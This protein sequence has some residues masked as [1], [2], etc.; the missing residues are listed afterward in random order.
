MISITAADL[1]FWIA[2]FIY[3]LTRILAFAA[4]APLWS[5]ASMP[6][7][8]RLLLGLALTLGLAPALPPMPATTPGTWS[9]LWLLSQQ[10]LI[11]I[12]MGLSMRIVYTA[13]NMA[14]ELIGLQMGLGFA[15][16]YDPQTAG[17]TPVIAEFLGIL[18]MLVF[19]SLNGHLLFAATLAQSFT[20]IPVS[21][22]PLAH[23]SWLNIAELGG[24]IFASGLLLSLPVVISLMISNTAL[25]VLTRAAPQ[26]NLFSLGFPLTLL[27]GFL[28][29]GLSLNYL[30]APLQALF[31]TALSAMLGFAEAR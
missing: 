9:G 24:K 26:L 25:A 13:I 12:G 28:I 14:G 18:A 8:T 21:T 10:L 22:T 17:Q 5:S 30:A 15:T 31:E 2:N 29:L 7:R 11:G 19:L 20:A 4:S 23:G 16:F 3:P 1:D 27:G 6:R